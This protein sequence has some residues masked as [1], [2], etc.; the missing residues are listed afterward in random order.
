[1]LGKIVSI[2]TKARIRYQGIL[3]K[4]EPQAL[5]MLKVVCKGTEGRRGN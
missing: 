5:H 3:E 2:I 4:I 1:M